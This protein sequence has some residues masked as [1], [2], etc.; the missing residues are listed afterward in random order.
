MILNPKEGSKSQRFIDFRRSDLALHSFAV[1]WLAVVISCSI[2]L[3]DLLFPLDCE[4]TL[5]FADRIS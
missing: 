2:E 4:T 5:R 3:Y 1:L